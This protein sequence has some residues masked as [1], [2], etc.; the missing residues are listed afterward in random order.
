M[1]QALPEIDVKFNKKLLSA[2]NTIFNKGWPD[3]IINK[4]YFDKLLNLSLSDL[5]ENFRNKES[6]TIL[7]YTLTLFNLNNITKS[8]PNWTS[9]V[10]KF[11]NPEE[12]LIFYK[13]KLIESTSK[14]D[15]EK[16]MKYL[17]FEFLDEPVN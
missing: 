9:I 5:I 2:F 11:S 10:C 3:E 17:V 14:F 6:L 16:I 1:I 4:K 7:P 8:N 13:G 12:I 15:E